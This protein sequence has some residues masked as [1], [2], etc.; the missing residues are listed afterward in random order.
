MDAGSVS[1]S[2]ILVSQEVDQ[3]QLRPS[4][5]LGPLPGP[6]GEHVVVAGALA[7]AAAAAARRPRGHAVALLAAE[8]AGPHA[9]APRAGARPPAPHAAL[10]RAEPCTH[11]RMCERR[12][13]RQVRSAG[14]SRRQPSEE[15][16]PQQSNHKGYVPGA[17][18]PVWSH[19]AA[20][21][22]SSR[23]RRIAAV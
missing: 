3:A 12:P 11:P 7:G 4:G 23:R 9:R 10:A 20:A 19:G 18:S 6:G 5:A 8:A 21:T 14:A 15:P 13:G 16:N 1:P 17:A 22:R 2:I